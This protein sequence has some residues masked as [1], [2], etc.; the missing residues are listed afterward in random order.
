[1][2]S[3]QIYGGVCL[4]GRF[5]PPLQTLERF[6]TPFPGP[7]LT[8]HKR[9]ALDESQRANSFSFRHPLYWPETDLP[10]NHELAGGEKRKVHEE[11]EKGRA[12][13]RCVCIGI[14]RFHIT[15]IS[16]KT[17]GRVPQNFKLRLLCFKL[18]WIRA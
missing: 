16:R 4:N 17:L 18:P 13:L 10:A 6:L 11:N 3:G 8:G 12:R 15:E 2:W 1:M 14:G 9:D 7:V 5:C